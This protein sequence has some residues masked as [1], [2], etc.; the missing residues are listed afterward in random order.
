M[1]I[2]ILKHPADRTTLAGRATEHADGL[3]VQMNAGHELTTY[4][5][6]QLFGQAGVQVLKTIRGLDGA[7]R[8][9]ECVIREFAIK[10]VS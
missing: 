2:P 9:S 3:L 4:E 6:G 1:L 10:G 8:I 7:D 5:A